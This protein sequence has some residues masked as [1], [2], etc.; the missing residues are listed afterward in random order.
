MAINV[1][2]QKE[3]QRCTGTAEPN[4]AS[5]RQQ[6]QVT[7]NS[8]VHS[9]KVPVQSARPNSAVDRHVVQRGT[10]RFKNLYNI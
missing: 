6:L 5:V 3:A 7:H 1:T 4:E 10:C 2:V 9:R 8:Y